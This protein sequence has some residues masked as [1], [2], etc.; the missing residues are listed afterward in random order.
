M[1]R[2]SESAPSRRGREQ[3]IFR[4]SLPVGGPRRVARVPRDA[5]V[6]PA[7][8]PGPCGVWEFRRKGS[9]KQRIMILNVVHAV[10]RLSSSILDL[11]AG[12]SVSAVAGAA[13]HT[14][15]GS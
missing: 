6:V 14:L 11:V 7:S 15:I 8:P 9:S 5:P 3:A 13:S 12:G 2:H 4:G 10:A 1:A